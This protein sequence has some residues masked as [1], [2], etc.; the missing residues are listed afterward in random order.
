MSS[1]GIFEIEMTIRGRKFSH[2]VTVVENI[3]DKILGIEFM[4]AHK[5][6]YDS[7]S[8]KKHLPTCKPMHYILLKK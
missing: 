1:L 8:K 6:N 2:P 3:N 4:H 5:L 7:S